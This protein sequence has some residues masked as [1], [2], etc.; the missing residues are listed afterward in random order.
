[1]EKNCFLSN[2]K[3]IFTNFEIDIS[4]KNKD[5]KE[6]IFKTNKKFLTNIGYLIIYEKEI[7]DYKD[8]EKNL[9]I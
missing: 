4:S 3:P 5:I 1:M 2:E 9:K 8:F 7:E 6:Y